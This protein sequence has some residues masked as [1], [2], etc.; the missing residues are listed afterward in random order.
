MGCS[1]A[2]ILTFC[3]VFNSN[4]CT[5][6]KSLTCLTADSLFCQIQF[7]TN[8]ILHLVFKTATSLKLH[9]LLGC[10]MRLKRHRMCEGGKYA[11]PEWMQLIWSK[12]NNVPLLYLSRCIW[13][14]QPA[15]LTQF[16]SSCWV[17][18][19]GTLKRGPISQRFTALC[20]HARSRDRG[21]WDSILTCLIW[22][23]ERIL[24]DC[25]SEVTAMRSVARWKCMHRLCHA[26]LNCKSVDV[27]CCLY[28]DAC[29]QSIILMIVKKAY[30]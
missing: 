6:Q 26:A 27:H 24:N 23:H 14:S 2:M 12:H 15:A 4:L 3:L 9:I 7:Q 8:N 20:W 16:T 28:K 10:F 22:E 19:G 25:T 17:A 30:I 1:M 13:P 5:G 11:V 18:G 21:L 29:M